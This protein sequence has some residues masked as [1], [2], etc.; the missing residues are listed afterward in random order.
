M[1]GFRSVNGNLIHETAII[2]W[3]AVEMGTGNKI[4][5][6]AA[7]GLDAQHIHAKS[8]GVIRI[9]NNNVIREYCSINMPTSQ[10]LK[11]QIGSNNYIMMYVNIGHDTIVEDDVTISNATQ[12]A[13]HCHLMKG[14][15]IGLGCKI[16]Q[17][18]VIGSFS[19]LGMGTIVT[20]KVDI[21][22]GKIYV[23]SPARFL[24]NNGIGLNRNNIDEEKLD[25]ET[26][27]YR[28]IRG[29]H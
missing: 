1:L 18:Q 29:V 25:A 11:T 27:R 28:E 15:N 12:V 2:N 13:G 21:L 10:R 7:I 16:H 3:D 4:Y 19:M 26:V 8:E 17:F 14:A 5:P 24:K 23:G 6:F 20:K 22:P 9:G